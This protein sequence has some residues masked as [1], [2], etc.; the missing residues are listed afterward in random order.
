MTARNT[1]DQPTVTGAMSVLRTILPVLRPLLL[2]VIAVALILVG[3]PA[4]LAA[5]TAASL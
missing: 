3:L 4:L 1:S 5:Q 2:V